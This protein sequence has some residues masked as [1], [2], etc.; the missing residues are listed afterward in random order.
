MKYHLTTKQISNWNTLLTW[1]RNN[2]ESYGYN[3]EEFED[4]WNMVAVDDAFCVGSFSIASEI[5][6]PVEDTSDSTFEMYKEDFEREFGAGTYDGIFKINSHLDDYVDQEFSNS[7]EEVADL[8]E[9]YL[10]TKKS[11]SFVYFG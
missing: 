1:M 2:E 4:N 7:L 11:L 8:L 6:R 10:K 9:Q 3:H 5:I